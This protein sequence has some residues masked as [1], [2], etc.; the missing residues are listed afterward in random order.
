M[1]EIANKGSTDRTFTDLVQL[2][3]GSSFMQDVHNFYNLAGTEHPHKINI[4]TLYLQK[5]FASIDEKYEEIPGILRQ[6]NELD[7][8]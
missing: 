4:M 1:Y 2:A 5:I 8:K 7:Q 6:I 3:R